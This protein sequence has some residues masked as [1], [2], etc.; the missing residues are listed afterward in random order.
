MPRFSGSLWLLFS[1][2]QRM[3]TLLPEP[4]ADV[5]SL[6]VQPCLLYHHRLLLGLASRLRGH[7][8]TSR[9]MESG[10]AFHGRRWVLHPSING[11]SQKPK[12]A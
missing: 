11:V 3:C 1:V 6:S 5:S 7:S 2:V 4:D 9:N 12:E 8:L 10:F